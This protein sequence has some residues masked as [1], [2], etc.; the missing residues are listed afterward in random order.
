MKPETISGNEANALDRSDPARDPAR[1]VE[2]ISPADQRVFDS[3]AVNAAL[4]HLAAVAGGLDALR[5]AGEGQALSDAQRQALRGAFPDALIERHCDRFS[6]LGELAYMNVTRRPATQ[7]R[8]SH[9]LT[10]ADRIAQNQQW[11]IAPALQQQQQLQSR[12]IA[13]REEEQDRQERLKQ[14]RE[15]IRQER[16]EERIIGREPARSSLRERGGLAL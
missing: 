7:E 6:R 15:E 2:P 10:P 9:S 5:A 3:L 13:Q 12:N 16:Q 11:E 14:A 4:P 8:Q 1:I